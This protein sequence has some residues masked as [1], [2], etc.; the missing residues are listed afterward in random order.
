MK[1]FGLLALEIP[2]LRQTWFRW[3]F[4]TLYQHPSSI[5]VVT[6]QR[7]FQGERWLF[8]GRIATPESLSLVEIQQQIDEYR[9]GSVPELFRKEL[10]LVR[11]PTPIRRMI[12][13]WNINL[14]RRKR[15]KRLGTFFLS[16]LAGQGVEIQIPPSIHT[17]CLTY[18]PLNKLGICKVTL[19]YDHRVMDGSLVADCL[20]RL[21]TILSET[22]GGELLNLRPPET[23]IHHIA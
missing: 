18:G 16:T 6:V 22:L 4:A 2:E 17:A 1:A 9:T 11:L 13:A 15:M 14:S 12:W 3:P 10:Q 23:K 7:E 21:E 20:S 8:W 5:G 19:A